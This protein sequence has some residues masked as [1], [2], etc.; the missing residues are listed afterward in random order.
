MEH[1]LVYAYHNPSTIKLQENSDGV[2]PL[3]SQLHPEAQRQSSAQFGFKATHTSILENQ[4]VLDYVIA[5]KH[6][7]PSIF[8]ESHMQQF[9][10]V[11]V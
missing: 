6:E 3:Y 8:P 1:H 10:R 5:K 7:V 11:R 2:V 9:A 4:E